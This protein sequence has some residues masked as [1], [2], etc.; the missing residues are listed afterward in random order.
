V[1]P[2][3]IEKLYQYYYRHDLLIGHVEKI[4]SRFGFKALPFIH[5]DKRMKYADGI[6]GQVGL[7]IEKISATDGVLFNIKETYKRGARKG[8]K[9]VNGV[10]HCYYNPKR[11]SELV[12]YPPYTKRVMFVHPKDC[13]RVL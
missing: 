2:D 7:D 10:Y 9:K 5:I 1:D 11:R 4:I 8:Q 3:Q 12:G 6:P 13:E